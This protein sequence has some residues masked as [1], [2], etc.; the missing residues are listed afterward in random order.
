MLRYLGFTNEDEA[1]KKTPRI[2]A[3]IKSKDWRWVT[4]QA[5]IENIKNIL[6]LTNNF[7]SDVDSCNFSNYKL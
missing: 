2:H 3:E 4:R 1:R 5:S 7:V 6:K